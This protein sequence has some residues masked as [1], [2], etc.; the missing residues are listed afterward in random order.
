MTDGRRPRVPTGL[1]L[2]GSGSAGT[3]GARRFTVH[4]RDRAPAS[5]RPLR[6]GWAAPALPWVRNGPAGEGK[7]DRHQ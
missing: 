6:H 3:G 5:I 1:P 7:R 2:P 4:V